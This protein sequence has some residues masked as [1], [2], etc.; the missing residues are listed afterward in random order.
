MVL[1]KLMVNNLYLS[2]GL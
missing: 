2:S 1:D